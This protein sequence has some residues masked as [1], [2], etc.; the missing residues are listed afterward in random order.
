MEITKQLANTSESRGISLK[1]GLQCNA[2]GIRYKGLAIKYFTTQLD[3]VWTSS[4]KY[5]GSDRIGLDR[6]GS[7]RVGSGRVGSGRVGSGRVGSGRVGSG[8]VGSGRIGSG[9]VGSGR[10]GSGRVGSGRVGSGRVGSGRVGSGRVGSGRV[11]SGRAGSGRVGSGRVGSGCSKIVS[12]RKSWTTQRL[13]AVYVANEWRQSSCYAYWLLI[14]RKT[15]SQSTTE[16]FRATWRDLIR[17][18]PTEIFRMS[19][20]VA[21]YPT[22]QFYNDP[23]LLLSGLVA[24]DRPDSSSVISNL[25]TS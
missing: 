9:R 6:V 1:A 25:V 24:I 14:C 4:S 16:Y 19:A 7:D 18:N 13:S 8:R 11:G 5:I 22:D 20:T 12:R 3:W 10:V 21:D 23:S 17:C 15:G 2:T